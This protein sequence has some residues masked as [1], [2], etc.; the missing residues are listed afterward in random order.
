M[1]ASKLAGSMQSVG[2]VVSSV[3]TAVEMSG[4]MIAEAME[5]FIFRLV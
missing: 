1:S 3:A 4:V 2:L 5:N